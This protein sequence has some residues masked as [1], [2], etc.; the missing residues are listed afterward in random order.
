MYFVN[1][2][3]SQVKA[4]D[5][6]CTDNNKQ[7]INRKELC[8]SHLAIAT[9]IAVPILVILLAAATVVALYFY[10]Q[11]QIKVWLYAKN[12][13]LWC[14]T[15]EELDKDKTYDVFISY[16]YKDED[17]VVQNLLPV[18]E[19]G[20]NPFKVCIHIRDWIPGEFI[21]RQV[22]NSVLDSR[23]TLVV[24]SENFLESVWGKMEFRTAH[25]QAISEGRARVVV[26]KYGKL[27]EE[28]LDDEL[29]AYLKT[30]TYVEWGDPWF[31]NKLKY[32]LPHSRQNNFYNNNQKHANIMLKIDDKFELTS[33]AVKH[34]ESTPPVVPLDPSLLKDHPLNFKADGTIPPT[35]AP[36]IKR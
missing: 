21:A 11:E 29:K 12:L 22:T 13:C 30:N 31:W 24:L 19:Q 17:F 14:V 25:T 33:S 5:V 8:K 20:P 32:A 28:N 10:Y 9:A 2:F 4:S 7:L 23:R 3:C 36:L 26:V 18:L 1:I 6:I 27:D 16:S 35:D 34:A 15:E